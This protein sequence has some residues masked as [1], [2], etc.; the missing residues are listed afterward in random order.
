MGLVRGGPARGRG[1]QKEKRKQNPAPKGLPR[2]PPAPNSPRRSRIPEL[3]D[4]VSGTAV[5]ELAQHRHR[6][7]L[8]THQDATEHLGETLTD[9]VQ[10]A[11]HDGPAISEIAIVVGPEGGISQAEITALQDAGAR[12]VVLG[13]HILRASTAGP[14]A[15]AVINERLGR[16]Y[17]PQATG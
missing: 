14:A 17:P 11:H 9:A 10:Q 15:V 4:P 13:T 2:G 7:V 6:L 16:W 1:G 8:V 12:I 5:A 3:R